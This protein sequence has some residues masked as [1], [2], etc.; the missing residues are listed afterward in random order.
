VAATV[1][2]GTSFTV[3]FLVLILEQPLASVPVTVY[4]VVTV[5][6]TTIGLE[7]EPLL[8]HV[9]DVAPDAVNVA[10]A[11]GQIPP[12][13]AVVAIAIV[14]NVFVVTDSIALFLQPLASVPVTV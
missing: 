7:V 4:C 2:V 8:T 14:G 12:P 11:S 6:L 13:P 10:D 9:Y 1:T 3:T 5:G